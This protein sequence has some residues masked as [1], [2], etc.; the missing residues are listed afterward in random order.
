MELEVF[1]L[2]V[3]LFPVPV[4]SPIIPNVRCMNQPPQ[5]SKNQAVVVALT[6][7]TFIVLFSGTIM[8]MGLISAP[9][10]LSSLV[11]EFYLLAKWATLPQ[12]TNNISPD[13][14]IKIILSPFVINFIGLVVAFIVREVKYG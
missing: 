14:R 13:L 6:I 11:F 5:V 12:A 3:S 10:G 2:R 7:N 8:D 1:G 9:L 4:I